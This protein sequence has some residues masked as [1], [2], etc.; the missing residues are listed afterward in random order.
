VRVPTDQKLGELAV[1]L[2][3]PESVDS[4][5]QWGYFNTIFTQTE[6]MET[7]IMEPLIAKMLAEDG[8]LKARFEAKKASDANFAKSPRAM[9]Q[10]FYAQTPYYDQNWKVIPVG[11][12]W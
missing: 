9:Y 6:Y 11:R 1:I 3:E 5:F 4:F 10:W 2:L 12:E 8:D 7:Y